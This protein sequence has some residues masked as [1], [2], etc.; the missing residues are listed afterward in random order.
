MVNM[1]GFGNYYVYYYNVGNYYVCYS[2]AK[3]RF[4]IIEMVIFNIGF[5]D[6]YKKQELFCWLEKY[7]I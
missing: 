1:D 5:I 4:L 6:I 7:Y 2:L 3:R